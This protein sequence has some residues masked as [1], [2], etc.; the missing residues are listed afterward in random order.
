[1]I[2][3][4]EAVTVRV[5]FSEYKPSIRVLENPDEK[6]ALLRWYVAQFPRA[7]GYLFSW[8]RKKDDPETT[9][10]SA[11]VSIIEIVELDR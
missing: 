10:I 8:D 1:M 4:Q 7:A 11:L 9:D 6:E 5:G 3:A 2:A